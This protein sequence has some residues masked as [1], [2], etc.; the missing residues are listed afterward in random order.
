MPSRRFLTAFAALA[1]VALPFGIP[2]RALPVDCSENGVLSTLR[3]YNL[4]LNQRHAEAGDLNGDGIPDLVISTPNSVT[5]ALATGIADGV[6]S[7]TPAFVRS[8]LFDPTGTAIGDFNGDGL[9]DI[10]ISQDGGPGGVLILLGNNSGAGQFTDGTPLPTPST[11]DLATADL[12]HDGILDL[13]VGSRTGPLFTYLG[14]GSAGLGNG[15]FTQV[16]SINTAISCKGIALADLDGDGIL[17]VVVSGETSSVVVLRGLGTNGV[18][19]GAFS[20]PVP[21]PAGGQT[22][23]VAVGDFNHDGRPDIASAN[24]TGGSISVLLASG[25]FTFQPAISHSCPGQPLGIGAA[26]IDHDGFDDLVVAAAGSG[27]A[28]SY[29]HN[30]GEARTTPDGFNAFATFAPARVS[31][32]LTVA[33]VNNDGSPDVLVPGIAEASLHIALNSCP[34]SQP[35][36]LTTDVVGDGSVLRS[37][38]QPSYAVGAVVQLTAQPAPGWVFSHWTGALS[39]STNPTSITMDVSH[40]VVA[41]FIAVQQTLSITLAGAG[42]GSVQRSPS[43]P[44]YD[45]GTTV[46]LAAVPEFGSVFTGWSG[47]LTGLANPQDLV[48]DGNKSVVATFDIDT[49]IVPRIVSITDVRLDQGGKLNLRWRPSE[50]ETTTTDPAVHV[51]QYYIWRQIPF[52]AFRAAATTGGTLYRRTTSGTRDYFWEFVTSLPASRFTGYSYT[53]ATTSDSSEHGNP[54]TSFL[55]QAR[56]AAGTR[57]FDSEPDSGYS[58]DNLSPTTPGPVVASYGASANALHWGPSRAPD[59]RGYRLHAGATRDFVPSDANLIAELTDT[60]FV[61]PAPR[62]LY[63][64]LAAVDVHGNLSHFVLVSPES[65]VATLVSLVSAEG[66]ADRIGITW[67]LSQ[68]GLAAS[69]YRRTDTS[70][71]RA[72]AQS[73]A[74]GSGFL[75]FDDRDV[76]R[77]TR[78]VYRLG[79]QDAGEEIFL[80]ETSVLAEDVRFALEGVA[81]NPSTGGAI[82]VRLILPSAEPGTIDLVDVS[83]RRVA[84]QRLAGQAGRQTVTLAGSSQLAPGLYW[85]RLQHAGQER[86]ARAVVIQ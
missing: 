66:A 13:V 42:H 18:G 86:T 79:I 85:I 56:N 51:T 84:S 26:D 29:F 24:Y 62:P 33:D 65:P 44:T 81:P 34:A 8:G 50:L 16:N 10:A 3:L 41:V 5:I 75:R 47:D 63:Y 22:Y 17:D 9:N 14:N 67:F 46:H 78:Y 57:W 2:A 49:G 40:S 76:V 19:N 30:Q 61:D 31:Y 72:V 28:F 15:T 7:Y 71:W 55:V 73:F 27:S 58:V 80:G 38:D 60:A 64:R 83:G 43:L 74:D 52:A 11:W 12:N 32:G 4:G 39:G 35:R 45:T 69:V 23:D 25:A 1:S 20:I 77:G 6:P 70:A 54:F 53:A 59:L 36:V 68:P 82:T 37:P 21:L 48:M